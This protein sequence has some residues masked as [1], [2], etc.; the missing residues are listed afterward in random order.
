MLFDMHIHTQE[1]S[2]DSGVSIK[3]ILSMAIE[4]GLSG[5]CITDHDSRGHRHDA[6]R[7]SDES[8]LVVIVGMEYT[9]QEG[10]LL[11]FGADRLKQYMPLAQALTEIKRQSGVAVAAHPFR[12]DTPL[13]GAA[14]RKCAQE[15][16]GV[17][18]FNGSATSTENLEAYNFAQEHGLLMFGGS[19]THHSSRLGRFATDIVTSIRDELDL[20]SH[21]KK[22]RE[23]KKIETIF[24]VARRGNG[25][26]SAITNEKTHREKI[27]PAPL[28][29]LSE[30]LRK[31]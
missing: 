3:K 10:H 8:G 13:M 4:V 20:I 23:N 2:P 22:A 1:Y 12:W 11:V 31:K 30:L 15:L 6:K 14:V 17:E 28:R 25:F 19:D 18:A 21:I 5:I 29:S 27:A 26:V 9:C 16:D 24:P 7:L